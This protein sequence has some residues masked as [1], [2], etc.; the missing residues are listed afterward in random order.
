MHAR[1]HACMGL[2]PPPL[3]RKSSGGLYLAS[4]VAGLINQPDYLLGLPASRSSPWVCLITG[5]STSSRL[6]RA[7]LFSFEL[8]GEEGRR[9]GAGGK[10]PERGQKKQIPRRGNATRRPTASPVCFDVHSRTCS[11]HPPAVS[12]RYRPPPFQCS[13]G[14]AA[15]VSCLLTVS[16][17]EREGWREGG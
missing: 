15:G 13:D 7:N 17:R 9:E 2:K 4:L 8:G 6:S 11:M 1:T 12:T 3:E 16:S 14:R 10:A 5:P